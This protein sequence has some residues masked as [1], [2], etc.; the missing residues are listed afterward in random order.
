MAKTTRRRF[1]EESLLV[2]AAAG[3]LPGAALASA[4][5]PAPRVVPPSANG[6][7]PL[8][9]AVIGL[10]GRGRGHI[11]TFKNIEGA[12]VV[13]LV[14]PES[15]E[16]V[17]KTAQ[18]SAPNAR[19]VRDLREVLEADDIDAVSI[20]TPNHWHAL[21][22]AW[23]L[24]SGKHVYV[25][26]PLT[27]SLR[28]GHEVV[29]A[30]AESGLVCQHGT[31][32]RS[33]SATR[34]AMAWLQSGAL[35]RVH[36]ARGLCYKRRHSIG[37]VDSDQP[38]PK[39]LDYDLWTGPARME[40]LRRTNLHY[41]WHWVYNTGDGDIGN[42]GV[43]QMDLARW[44]LGANGLPT[45]VRSVGGRLGYDDDGNTANTQVSS[46]T[47]GDSRAIFEVRGLETPHAP[48]SRGGVGVVWIADEGY[49]V[50]VS[51]NN[52]V[53]YDTSGKELR[54][55]T[56]GDDN[57]HFRNWVEAARAGDPSRLHAAPIEGHYSSGMC[58]LGNLSYRLGAEAGLGERRPL[59]A[60]ATPFGEGEDPGNEAF[61][62]M[63]EHLAANGVADDSTYVTGPALK[64]D[65]STER[66][67]GEHAE[68]AEGLAAGYHREGYTFDA[69]G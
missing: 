49:L 65:P 2:A 67:F 33:Y 53:A 41:D 34:E 51:Y 52:L 63:R 5:Q 43:H 38:I 3:T 30:A 44:G 23:A 36:V 35:G 69:V 11:G 28:E 27:H 6:R 13:A 48:K 21:G 7:D 57:Q 60:T 56:G 46:Y 32:A 17:V 42:Q 1:L 62:R 14:D 37:K 18:R 16:A 26:K 31:Q 50:S 55:F 15:D 22:A 66:F 24:R 61:G 29:R 54:R 20:A 9:I 4:G 47:F 40:P 39:S 8:R 12:E 19:Y 45:E 59:S 68:A 10:R 58:Q 64:F 25:E